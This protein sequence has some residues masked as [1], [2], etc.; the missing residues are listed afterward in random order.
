MAIKLHI[1]NPV[2]CPS[3][4]DLLLSCD[5]YSFFQSS[6]WAK[7]LSESYRYEPLYLTG[8]SHGELCISIPLMEVRSLLT[9]KRGVSLPFTDYCE[10]IVK[11]KTHFGPAFEYLIDCGLEKEWKFIE[12]R[13]G[14]DSLSDSPHSSYYYGH[15]LHLSKDEGEL[16]SNFRDSTKRSIKKAIREGVETNIGHTCESVDE[17]FRLNCITRKMHGLPPQPY[18]FFKSVFEHII[19]KRQGCIV[20]ASYQEKTIAASMY[21][22]FGNKAVYKYGASDYTYQ[23]L[24][25]N[26]LV[27]WEAIK[28]YARNGY[29]TLC[30]GRTE[31]ENNGLRQFKAGWG[32]VERVIKYHRY[33]L[34]KRRFTR[35]R[36]RISGFH[37]KIFSRIPVLLSRYIGK[38]LYRHVG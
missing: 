23:H 9:G 17:F 21:F 14:D 36:T 20:L 10:P 7:V 15:T 31:S 4:D 3:W 22:Q 13:C 33:D 38:V 1:I 28:W 6:S 12:M 26:N 19:S 18:S 2:N 30:F 32:T 29:K 35:N 27:M 16:F 24:R 34:R 25:A 8:I 5:D 37:N 11:N